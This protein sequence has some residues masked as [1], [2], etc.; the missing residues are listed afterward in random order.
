VPGYKPAVRDYRDRTIMV[1]MPHPW[2]GGFF[3]VAAA[4]CNAI[5]ELVLDRSRFRVILGVPAGYDCTEHYLLNSDIS[6]E[7]IGYEAVAADDTRYV[8]PDKA[9]RLSGLPLITPARTLP[10]GDT[11]VIGEVDAYILLSALFP[12]GVFV[13]RK[14][15][16]VYIADMIQR[17]VPEIYSDAGANYQAP[18]WKMDRHQRAALKEAACIFSTT[19]QTMSDTLHYGGVDPCKT[20]LFPMFALD[21]ADCQE[22]EVTSAAPARKQFELK[23]LVSGSTFKVDAGKYF[24]WVT[25]AAAHKNH[26]NAF[27]ALR[28][29][30]ENLGGNLKCLI[31]GPVTDLLIP[32]SGGTGPYHAKIYKELEDWN[33]NQHLKVLGYITDST[34]VSLLK[35]AKFLWHNVIYDNGTFSIIE[36][37][38]VGTPVLSSAYPQ[39]RFINDTFA[40]GSLFFEAR[41]PVDAATKIRH[42]EL[43]SRRTRPRTV[44]GVNQTRFECC[45]AE[46][47][48][49]MFKSLASD[50]KV[51]RGDKGVSL[52]VT[53][54]AVGGN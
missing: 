44:G 9:E 10:Y 41:D 15:Y 7:Q 35:A 52:A 26:T 22:A 6:V 43:R 14:P 21:I 19:E 36:A 53:S 4:I 54:A 5:D 48:D 12:E 33:F 42:M 17:Y 18:P 45:L 47:V 46:L 39:I 2:K 37:A 24:L 28:H 30:Y 40:V 13:S 27:R 32:R 1:V 38:S 29:Y 16:A 49:R 25:N 51:R 34:Y 50:E 8:A 23:D 20:M 3:R 31:C 11:G